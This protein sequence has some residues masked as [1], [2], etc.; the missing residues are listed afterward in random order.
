MAGAWLVAVA[1]FGGLR[2]HGETLA[3]APRLPEPLT[4]LAFRLLY[5]GRRIHVDVNS[6]HACYK[7][8]SGE[9]L[10]VFHHGEQITIARDA[11]RTCH[12]PPL[13]EP[14]PVTPPPG[15]DPCRH[16]IG[17]NGHDGHLAAQPGQQ[18][19]TAQTT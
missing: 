14:P 4:R 18:R 3:F 12:Y 10:E 2:D 7:L 5:R 19:T 16:G 8:L 6:D 11:P 15:R 1:G 17:A 13:A 9:P